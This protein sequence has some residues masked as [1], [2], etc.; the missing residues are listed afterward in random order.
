ME[1]IVIEKESYKK[2]QQEQFE[3]FKK[4]LAEVHAKAK[5]QDHNWITPKEAHTLLGYRSKT[6]LQEL[7]DRGEIQYSQHGRTIMYSRKSI[8]AFL[9]RNIK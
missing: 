6:K 1:V 9:E 8:I 4:A 5:S 2:L 3:R 7:R